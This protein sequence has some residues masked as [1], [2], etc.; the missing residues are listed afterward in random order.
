[1]SKATG[2][3]ERQIQRE[4]KRLEDRKIIFQWVNSKQRKISFNK[5]YGQWVGEIDIGEIDNPKKFDIG[6]IDI[7][8]IDNPKK[9]DIGEIDNGE[10]DIGETDIGEIDN[11]DIGEID[12]ADIGEIDNQENYIFKTNIKTNIAAAIKNPVEKIGD[13]FFE[14]TGRFANGNDFVAITK[15]LEKYQDIETIIKIM[16]EVVEKKNKKESSN[17]IKSF[18]YFVGAIEDGFKKK[19]AIK[20]GES[21]GESKQDNKKDYDY[22]NLLYKDTG[23][24]YSD[25]D[26]DF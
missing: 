25:E 1:L 11:A 6:E 5:K 13:L 14:L 3:N 21:I 9:F 10:T 15:V 17:N 2:C 4:L 19:D 12:N 7:G 26:I 16:T 23:V 8:E 20:A 24:I 22:S 18:S